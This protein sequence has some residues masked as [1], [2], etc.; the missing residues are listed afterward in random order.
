MEKFVEWFGR[1]RKPIGYAVGGLN[2]LVALSHLIQGH[3]GLAVLWLIIGAA[4]VFDTW[5]FK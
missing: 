1:N 5:E 3:L 4:I 2:L